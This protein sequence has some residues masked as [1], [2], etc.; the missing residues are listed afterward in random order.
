[1]ASNEN[2]IFQKI[3]S[4][5]GYSSKQLALTGREI[6]PLMTAFLKQLPLG[7]SEKKTNYIILNFSPDKTGSEK[8][9]LLKKRL[10]QKTA[11]HTSLAGDEVLLS[12]EIHFN[13][14][15][16]DHRKK[17][18]ALQ[19]K[20][21]PYGIELAL[22]ARGEEQLWKESTKTAELLIMDWSTIGGNDLHTAFKSMYES[23]VFRLSKLPPI[24]PTS[25]LKDAEIAMNTYFLNADSVVAHS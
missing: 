9:E 14:K 15:R 5:Y 21:R 22:V 4:D 1:M 6:P 17:A 10:L 3:L 23:S 11:S 8:R 16:K 25:S 18:L 13:K 12:T 2:V 7:C 20:L 24:T 19:E